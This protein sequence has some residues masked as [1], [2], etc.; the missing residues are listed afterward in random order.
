MRVGKTTPP[1]LLPSG[2]KESDHTDH[3]L[4]GTLYAGLIRDPE[5]HIL[6]STL[7][8]QVNL[9]IED[10]SLNE[11]TLPPPKPIAPGR[12]QGWAILISD[13]SCG[14][15]ICCPHREPT[16]LRDRRC[17]KCGGQQCRYDRL[18]CLCPP[19]QV[20]GVPRKHA[21]HYRVFGRKRLLPRF[22]FR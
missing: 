10:T 4:R 12:R 1:R 9:E 8:V 3:A 6:Q 17:G 5:G 18:F 16:K 20:S 7:C 21:P 2:F 15:A 14:T 13:M 19:K 11:G 22:G